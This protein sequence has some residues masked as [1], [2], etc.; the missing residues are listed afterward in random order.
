M[1]RQAKLMLKL[2]LQDISII[3]NGIQRPECVLATRAG[4]LF[5]SDSRGGYNIINPDGQSSFIEAIGVPDDLLPNGIALLPNR[6]ILAANLADSS[7]VWRINRDGQ[8]CLFLDEAD[9]IKLPPVNFVGLDHCDRLW[10]SVS[11]RAVPRHQSFRN[12]VAD[13]FIAVHD[14]GATRIVADD[15][16][17]TNESIVDPS[18]AWLYVN[19]TIGQCTS[20]YPISAEASL[21]PRE[22]V[23]EYPPGTFP[24]GLTFDADGRVWIVSVASNRIICVDRGGKQTVVFEDADEQEME[25]LNAA[26]D[27]GEIVRDMIEIGVTR[28]SGNIASIAFGGSNLQTIYLGSLSHNGIQKFSSPIKGVRPVHWKF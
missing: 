17:F 20:R 19:E 8:A 21:G 28:S 24:D 11:T 18:G 6:D 14:Q 7:G 1:R 23:A 12:G 5:C 10:I 15:I 22:L 27:R 2:T 3:G 16:A 13:G 26:F 25:V 4:Y 9:G